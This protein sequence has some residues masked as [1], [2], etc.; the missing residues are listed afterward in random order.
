MLVDGAAERE[1][2]RQEGIKADEGAEADV[3]SEMLYGLNRGAQPVLRLTGHVMSLKRLQPGDAV[4]Y[5]YTFRAERATTVALITGGYAQA[6]VRLLGNR[7]DVEVAGSLHPIVGRVA[8]DVCV[9]EVGDADGVAEG[10]EV[11]YFG[12]TGPVRDAISR[13]SRVTGMAPLELV[14]A[15]GLKAAQAEED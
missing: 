14:C 5:G 3:S 6:V 12:G 4:S 8:M 7:M 1:R 15:A 13:W 10:V 9:I 2:L 11:T